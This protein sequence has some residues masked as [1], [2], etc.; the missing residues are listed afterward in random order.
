[1]DAIVDSS[2][3]ILFHSIDRLD[4]LTSVFDD[5][6]VPQAVWEEVTVQSR[7]RSRGSIGALPAGMRR[8]AVEHDA[9][10]ARWLADLGP[11]ETDVI[12]L[13]RQRSDSPMLVMDDR[14]ARQ[15][16]ERAGL[17]VM[18]SLGVVLAAKE[19]G[20]V[21]KAVPLLVALR[22]AGLIASE[23]LMAKVMLMANE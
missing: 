4:I 14:P 16:A 12:A 21:P 15:V 1:M 18:G 10:V 19:I 7:I 8:L 2:P 23:D 17:T 11:G 20:V 9:S 5:I 13:G 3:L 22:N 6:I